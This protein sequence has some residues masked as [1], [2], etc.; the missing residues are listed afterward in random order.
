MEMTM[1]M[2]MKTPSPRTLLSGRAG[3]MELMELMEIPMEMIS[4]TGA[5]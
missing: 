1:E 3:A 2:E 4:R 5:R